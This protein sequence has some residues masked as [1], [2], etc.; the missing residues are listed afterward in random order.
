M[1]CKNNTLRTVSRKSLL[2]RTGVEY[3]DFCINHVEGCSHGCRYPC[4]AMMMKRRAGV[5]SSYEDWCQPKL[6]SNAL[7]LLEKEIPRYKNTIKSV[8]LCF[9]TDPFMYGQVEIEKL[10]IEIIKRLNDNKISCTVLTKGLYPI[11]DITGLNGHN[12][13]GVTIVSLDE[14]FR[15]NYEPNT[16]RFEER[17]ETLKYLHQKG[18]KTWVSI[19]PYPTPNIIKQD[20]MKILESIAFVDYIV[21]GK[22]NYNSDTKKFL[23]SKAF[24]NSQAKAVKSF[25]R[26][27]KIECYI[28]EGTLTA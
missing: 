26:K 22:L 24:Y 11:E 15:K 21:F 23:H 7:E 2:Y 19:E 4:Y 16:A 20:L 6:V 5:I 13:Y 27:N 10:S 18:F 1:G 25:C 14:N 9:A 28:K 8:H 3:G 12:E 17:I